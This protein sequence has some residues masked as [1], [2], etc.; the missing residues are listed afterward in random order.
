M[1]NLDTSNSFS[2]FLPDSAFPSAFF[3]YIARI[4]SQ[5]SRQT[6]EQNL[7]I[8]CM[9]RRIWRWQEPWE[10]KLG[11][12]RKSMKGFGLYPAVSHSF[13]AGGVKGWD[14]KLQLAIQH[15]NPWMFDSSCELVSSLVI[16]KFL[17]I[18]NTD[19]IITVFWKNLPCPLGSLSD[20]HGFH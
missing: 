16:R 12:L 15:C 13:V 1:F 4:Y 11:E 20:A 5:D 17:T 6:D 8:L 2:T 10:N 14:I 9:C 18:P 7:V 19:S 3:H